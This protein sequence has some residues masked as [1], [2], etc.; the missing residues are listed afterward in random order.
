MPISFAPLDKIEP[1]AKTELPGINSRA[2][3]ISL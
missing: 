3:Y 2:I 1:A